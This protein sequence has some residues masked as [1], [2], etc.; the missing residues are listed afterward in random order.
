MLLKT[1][2]NSSIDFPLKKVLIKIKK[3]ERNGYLSHIPH[4][5]LGNSCGR[6]FSCQFEMA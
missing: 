6:L 1:Y 2:L 3:K 4:H 5:D